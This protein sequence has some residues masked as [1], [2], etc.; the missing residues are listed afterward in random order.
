M[1]EVWNS[2]AD[3]A[4]L[5]TAAYLVAID[6]VAKSY[7]AKGR[8]VVEKNFAAVDAAIDHLHEV[9]VPGSVP[10]G[11]PL[12]ALVPDNAPA[13]VQEV[14]AAMMRG[15][16]DDLPVSMLPVDGTWP[17]SRARA[18]AWSSAKLWRV[19]R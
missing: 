18:I 1:T 11:E 6:R 14:T 12:P 9:A 16:G 19:R 2:R 10:S 17:S 13:F 3:V 7:R 5:R 8:A 15:H 4:D